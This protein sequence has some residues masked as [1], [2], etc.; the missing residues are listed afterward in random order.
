MSQDFETQTCGNCRF[1]VK[2]PTRPNN[3]GAPPEGT[4]RERLQAASTIIPHG[5]VMMLP[6]YIQNIPEKHPACGQFEERRKALL[7]GGG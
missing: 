7:T 1:W 5:Q 2:Q 6:I 4:C 3:L